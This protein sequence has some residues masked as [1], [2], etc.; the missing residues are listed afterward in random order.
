LASG[1]GWSIAKIGDI[2]GDGYSDIAI[3]A[4]LYTDS[5]G[6]SQGGAVYVVFMNG[7]KVLNYVMLTDDSEQKHPLPVEVKRINHDFDVS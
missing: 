2:N 1:F 6:S 7:T 3:G 5:H 4:P